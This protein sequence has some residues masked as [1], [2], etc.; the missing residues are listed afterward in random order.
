[1]KK[2]V[3]IIIVNFV[4]FSLA[5]S[6][7]VK[8]K[9]QDNNEIQNAENKRIKA[10]ADS[11]LSFCKKND[12]NTDYC[13]LIDFSKHSGKYR[14]F[15]WDFNT[16]SIKLS[17]LCAHG[18]GKESTVTKPVFS[19]VEGSYCSSIGKYKTGIRS[20]SQYGINVHYKLHGLEKTNNNAFKRF[21]V[22]HSHT[23]ISNKEIYPGH[24]PLGYS[25]G[26][27][28]LSNESM[29][30]IDEMLKKSEKSVLLWI[31]N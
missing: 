23:P 12:L 8:S 13:F 31:Y 27:P 15:V 11:A 19:N 2:Q 22:L 6:H 14:F 5:C 30:K 18:Y 3:L 9:V 26:C 20:Y 1:M 21:I 10:K 25:Q 17:S 16:Q 24:L 29:K 4:I 28:V 7:D